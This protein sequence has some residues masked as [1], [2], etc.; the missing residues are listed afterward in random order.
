[1]TM[2]GYGAVENDGEDGSLRCAIQKQNS[3]SDKVRKS[4]R[5]E[6]LRYINQKQDSTA[7]APFGRMALQEMRPAAAR[8]QRKEQLERFDEFVGEDAGFF[9][10]IAGAHPIF[11]VDGFVGLG[12]EVAYFFDEIVLRVIEL[13]AFGDL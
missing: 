6:G 2:L 5:P 8:F 9:G 10:E 11:A 13:F 4:W 12:E 1:M 7:T 3:P